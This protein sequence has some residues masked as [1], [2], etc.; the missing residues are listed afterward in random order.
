VGAELPGQPASLPESA[1]N[2]KTLAILLLLTSATQSQQ[3]GD[4]NRTG[5]W[6]PTPDGYTW[7][8]AADK[9]PDFKTTWTKFEELEATKRAAIK[10]NWPDETTPKRVEVAEVD[11]NG[12]GR[13]EVFVG[14]PIYSGT[15]GTFYEILSTKDGKNYTSVG[16][17]Q[18]SGLQF[19]LRKNGWFQIEGTSRG[20]GGNHTRFLMSFVGESYE[21]TR[22][23]NHDFNAGKATVRETKAKKAVTGQPG[24]RP[25]LKSEDSQKSRLESEG[26]S[27]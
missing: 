25:K 6:L 12:D 26:H 9:A 1:K 8:V 18:G 11:L 20:G 21:I 14:V 10:A 16:N 2:M 5:D 19:L 13:P 4:G 24:S 27:R 15:G 17:I 22:N 3:V 23:E 7:P